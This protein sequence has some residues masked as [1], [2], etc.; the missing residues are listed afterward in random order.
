MSNEIDKYSADIS[1]QNIPQQFS[2]RAK[3]YI[4]KYRRLTDWLKASRLAVRFATETLAKSELPTTKQEYAL[5]LVLQGDRIMPMFIEGQE[6]NKRWIEANH[7]KIYKD[8][9]KHLKEEETTLDM[10]FL[11]LNNNIKNDSILKR[12]RKEKKEL[13]DFGS[14]LMEDLDLEIQ[15]LQSISTNQG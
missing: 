15:R 3:E 12:F 13:I 8:I 4:E 11:R 1:T 2:V 10:F 14:K 6:V 5:D 7:P 9:L